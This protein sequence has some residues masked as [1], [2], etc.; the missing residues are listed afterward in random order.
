MAAVK[1]FKGLITVS[2][3]NF[4]FE[5]DLLLDEDSFF[6]YKSDVIEDQRKREA[7]DE[8][9]KNV[10]FPDVS[11]NAWYQ[12]EYVPRY[13]GNPVVEKFLAEKGDLL[14]R[15]G[16]YIAKEAEKGNLDPYVKH[17]QWLQKQNVLPADAQ[18]VRKYFDDF[19]EQYGFDNR[20]S[21][22][23]AHDI[24]AHGIPEAYM[25]VVDKSMPRNVTGADEARATL[26]ET[27]GGFLSGEPEKYT[28]EVLE[29]TLEGVREDVKIG[30]PKLYES[31]LFGDKQLE[32]EAL[33][34]DYIQKA[35]KAGY[36]HPLY[37]G[38]PLDQSFP[39][40]SD[41]DTR[42]SDKYEETPWADNKPSSISQDIWKAIYERFPSENPKDILDF[43]EKAGAPYVRDLIESDKLTLAPEVYSKLGP[44][45]Y[46]KP[47]NAD[48]FLNN[49][50]FSL[51]PVTAAASAVPGIARNIK[52]APSSLLPGVADLIPSPEAIRTGYAQ[53]PVAM[54]KQMAQE[55]AQSLPTAAGASMLLSTPVAAPLAPGIGAG[56]VGTAAARALNEVVR[57]ETGEGIVPKVRQFLGTAPRTGVSAPT[58]QSAKPLVAEIKPLTAAQRQQMNKNQ[59]RSD[60][61]RRM[62]LAKERFNPRKGE[63][64]LSE[65]LFGR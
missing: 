7:F 24:Y 44:T 63:F 40:V 4:L 30:D 37:E 35:T 13:A 28:P 1:C 51:D 48:A 22:L 11:Q 14:K 25:G 33:R 15:R 8:Q 46:R 12:N 2:F 62:D 50:M 53:G 64:G 29:Q 32:Y 59:T 60:M 65:L 39:R 27:L 47:G 21:G 56:L 17:S 41:P 49:T 38:T 57:Q 23:T 36:F 5:D 31:L 55:F 26:I 9:F 3:D 6:G 18:P 54:G 45:D 34:D 43:Y 20:F 61:Q 16:E 10:F 58:A 42:Y 19:T 52:R